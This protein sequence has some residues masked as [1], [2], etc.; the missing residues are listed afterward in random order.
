MVTSGAE[1]QSRSGAG[2][3]GVVAPYVT[4]WSGELDLP[5]VMVERPGGGVGYRDEVVA[6]RD[7]RGVLWVR[8]PFCPGEGRPEFGR[9]HPVR[10]RRAMQR[11]L[12]QVCAGPADRTGDGVL[13][14]LRDH[15]DDWPSWPEGM[16][17]TEPPVCVPCVGLSVRLCPALRAGAVAVRVGVY[18]VAGVH[19]GLY[20]AGHGGP[21]PVRRAVVSFDDPAVRWVRAVSLVR[22]LGDCTIVPVADLGGS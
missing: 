10:Q 9:V 12:C 17:V 7:R 3:R 22:R 16:G 18:P 1:V 8:T 4:A 21:V 2:G 6:D 20:R 5:V 19:G 13:W 14:L 11:L 15:R